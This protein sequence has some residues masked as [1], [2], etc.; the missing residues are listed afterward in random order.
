MASNSPAQ[1]GGVKLEEG[2]RDDTVHGVQSLSGAHRQGGGS[3][4]STID[5]AKGHKSGTA[6]TV[7]R[8]RRWV[9]DA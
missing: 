5:D 8:G 1:G 7:A 4:G 9:D 3:G 6:C 2:A